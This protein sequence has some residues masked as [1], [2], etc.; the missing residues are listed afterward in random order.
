ML[1]AAPDGSEED[2]VMTNEITLK[3]ILDHIQG[4]RNA[5]EERMNLLDAKVERLQRTI[6]M[7]QD[8]TISIK[9]KLEKTRMQNSREHDAFD[10][11]LDT[12]EIAIIEQK[13]ECRIQDLEN[14]AGFTK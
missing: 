11:R 5:I 12:I 8:D 14:F 3:D 9:V 4:M 10:K 1:L 6:E 13:H 2:E 7:V